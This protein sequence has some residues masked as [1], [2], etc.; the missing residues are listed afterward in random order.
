MLSNTGESVEFLKYFT[1]FTL[2]DSDKIINGEGYG[3]N[4]VI[5]IIL[6]IILY[7]SGLYVFK[8]RDLPL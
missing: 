8:K 5:L 6:A 3:I 1:L 7:A 2:L 4:F